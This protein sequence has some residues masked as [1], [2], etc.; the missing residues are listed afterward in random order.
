[1]SEWKD[2]ARFMYG[3]VLKDRGFWYAHPLWEIQGLSEEQLFWVPD[4]HCLCMLWQ[5]GHIAHRERSHIGLFLQGIREGLIPPQYE[6]FGADWCSVEQVRSSIGSVQGV[7]DWVREVRA[8]SAEFVEA[9]K[10]E[11]WHKVPVSTPLGEPFTVAHWLFITVAHGAIHIGRIQMLR[12][13]LLGEHDRA[14]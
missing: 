12:A 3:D 5:V 13:M 9:L 8:R 1:M 10:D 11:D 14:C 4:A 2:L 7:L 6:V